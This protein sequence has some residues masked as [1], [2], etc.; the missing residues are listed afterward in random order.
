[1]VKY[2]SIA[3]GNRCCKNDNIEYQN[4]KSQERKN[5]ISRGFRYNAST[6]PLGFCRSCKVYFKKKTASKKTRSSEEFAAENMTRTSEDHSLALVVE[7]SKRKTKTTCFHQKVD[8][9]CTTCQSTILLD[10]VRIIK[11]KPLGEVNVKQM[12]KRLQEAQIVVKK[13]LNLEMHQ[14]VSFSKTI[15]GHQD[16]VLFMLTQKH[17]FSDFFNQ[18]MKY[19]SRVQVTNDQYKWIRN[20]AKSE[21][22]IMS[23]V[24]TVVREIR[25]ELKTDIIIHPSIKS[26]LSESEHQYVCIDNRIDLGKLISSSQIDLPK[27]VEDYIGIGM[28]ANEILVLTPNAQDE[29]YEYLKQSPDRKVLKGF[30]PN[31]PTIFLNRADDGMGVYK[32]NTPLVRGAFTVLNNPK[33]LNDPDACIVSYIWLGIAESHAAYKTILGSTWSYPHTEKC[34]IDTKTHLGML[35]KMGSEGG[36]INGISFNYFYS[37]CGDLPATTKV[38]GRASNSHNSGMFCCELPSKDRNKNEN[39]YPIRTV[40]SMTLNG[41]SCCQEVKN[42]LLRRKEG[43]T[44][45][46]TK[47]EKER[48]VNNAKGQ[49][50]PPLLPFLHSDFLFCDVLH[51]NE[52]L[53]KITLRAMMMENN[54]QKLQHFYLKNMKENKQMKQVFIKIEIVATHAMDNGT[55]DI[56]NIKKTQKSVYHNVYNRKGKENMQLRLDGNMVKVR[57]G[58]EMKLVRALLQDVICDGMENETEFQ[59]TDRFFKTYR[60][61]IM[62]SVFQERISSIMRNIFPSDDDIDVLEHCIERFLYYLK[63]TNDAIWL[64][65]QYIHL[66]GHHVVQQMRFLKK[67]FGYGLAALQTN[68]SEGTNIDVKARIQKSNN[69]GDRCRFVLEGRVIS[70]LKFTDLSIEI[71]KT[72]CKSCGSTTHSMHDSKCPSSN[73][74]LWIDFIPLYDMLEDSFEKATLKRYFYDADIPLRESNHCR[75]LKTTKWC[76]VHDFFQLKKNGS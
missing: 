52:N 7:S 66:L 50:E 4:L 11:R 3:R 49:I 35:M 6:G 59:I 8:D 25:K 1:M 53:S 14:H 43:D 48:A 57:E 31:W 60:C 34:T 12:K 15:D 5:M 75:F 51:G 69:S 54:D 72:S 42:I 40:D 19:H 30:N 21:K 29:L 44:R 61:C 26:Y 36:K 27:V 17:H 33:R 47:T 22:Y 68:V 13:I 16:D 18:A 37:F 10:N 67:Y 23:D 9:E 65:G 41:V 46:I 62:L 2:C 55:F 45:G 24:R 32:N 39:T 38:L 58:N 71:Q 64:N 56:L 74:A 20:V 76:T 70:F 63:K 73:Q 28:S